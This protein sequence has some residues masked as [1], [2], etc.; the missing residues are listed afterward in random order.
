MNIK[1]LFDKGVK[2]S[3][4]F[5]FGKTSNSERTKVVC[6]KCGEKSVVYNGLTKEFSC[7]NKHY[8]EASNGKD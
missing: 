8:W 5:R 3:K 6:P 2:V 1:E 4:D 7:K